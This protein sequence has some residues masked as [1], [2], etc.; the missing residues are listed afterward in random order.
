MSA[1]C[2]MKESLIDPVQ[3]PSSEQFALY[4][5][6]LGWLALFFV[7]LLKFSI[8]YVYPLLA[9]GQSFRYEEALTHGLPGS[10]RSS[11]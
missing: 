7:S 10:Y 5:F 11:S 3:N 2:E 1:L 9:H 8:S 6:P 4:I